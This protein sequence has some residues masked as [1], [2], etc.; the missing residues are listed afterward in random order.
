MIISQ[1]VCQVCN[2]KLIEK[3]YHKA[4]YHC[5]NI[6]NHY[7]ASFGG[8][9]FDEFPITSYI[10]KKDIDYCKCQELVDNLNNDNNYFYEKMYVEVVEKDIM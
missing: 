7:E 10:S 5:Y 6:P 3:E 1:S 2:S 8:K 9:S 4:R